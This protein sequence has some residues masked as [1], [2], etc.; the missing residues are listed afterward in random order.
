[1]LGDGDLL[2]EV[3]V[4]LG[5]RT[6]RSGCRLFGHLHAFP[7]GCHLGTCREWTA[8]GHPVDAPSVPAVV[9]GADRRASG[10]SRV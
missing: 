1:M 3:T 4:P 5:H 10:A 6:Q 8:Q 9:P 2:A 7:L